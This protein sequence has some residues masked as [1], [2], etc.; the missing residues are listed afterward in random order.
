MNVA[1]LLLS[2]VPEMHFSSVC[3]SNDQTSTAQVNL[4]CL[5]TGMASAHLSTIKCLSDNYRIP[6]CID[7]SSLS[8]ANPDW[9]DGE[10]QGLMIVRATIQDETTK[11]QKCICQVAHRK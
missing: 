5:F 10:M 6:Q 4:S 2:V 3:L 11:I 7:V 9:E 1:T 8:V